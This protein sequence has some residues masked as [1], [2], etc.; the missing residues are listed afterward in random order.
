MGRAILDPATG[1]LEPQRHAGTGIAAR[2]GV[3]LRIGHMAMS[4]TYARAIRQRNQD[5]GLDG[6]LCE[7][8]PLPGLPINDGVRKFGGKPMDIFK[9]INKGS[10]PEST[11]NNGANILVG[12]MEMTLYRA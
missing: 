4:Q 6:G 7:E 12:G 9:L 11:G 3:P 2:E 8:I 1:G 10:P 5:V